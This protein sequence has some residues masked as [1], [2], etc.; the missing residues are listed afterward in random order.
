MI[1]ACS[2]RPYLDPSYS[3]EVTEYIDVVVQSQTI[4]FLHALEPNSIR[5]DIPTRE[6]Q[7]SV[8]SGRS[9]VW[10]KLVHQLDY[11]G[12]AQNIL[13]VGEIEG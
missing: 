13:E 8:R 2:I 10:I 7:T 6:Y 5:R 9:R 3:L 12:S 11:H 1:V 4:A